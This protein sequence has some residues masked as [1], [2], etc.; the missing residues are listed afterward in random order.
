[1]AAEADDTIDPRLNAVVKLGE[2]RGWSVEELTYQVFLAATARAHVR[3][4][5]DEL[6]AEG[7]LEDLGGGKYRNVKARPQ[8]A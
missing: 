7:K 6:V 2:V 1:M 5:F 4:R 8:A 3:Q